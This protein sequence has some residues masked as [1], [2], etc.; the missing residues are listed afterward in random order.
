M[1]EKSFRNAKNHK[2]YR[3]HNLSGLKMKTNPEYGK[4]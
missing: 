2:E 3:I 1:C 4:E